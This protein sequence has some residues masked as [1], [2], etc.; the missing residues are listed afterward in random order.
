M[1]SE[2]APKNFRGDPHLY[3]RGIA[4]SALDLVT[5]VPHLLFLKSQPSAWGLLAWPA[6]HAAVVSK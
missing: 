1:Y 3:K 6:S 5:W 2:Y 4:Q